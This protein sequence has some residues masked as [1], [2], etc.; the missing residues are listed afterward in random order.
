MTQRTVRRVPDDERAAIVQLCRDGVS[1]PEICLRYGRSE[2]TVRRILREV[3]R[4]P[5][6][7][8][9]AI[10]Q[11]TKDEII[12]R[13]NEGETHLGKLAN[14]LGL[15]RGSVVH[16]LTHAG[17]DTKRHVQSISKMENE[18]IIEE[19]EFLCGTDTLESLC[20]RLDVKPKYLLF[21]LLPREGRTDL[22]E[23]LMETRLR[24]YSSDTDTT[25]EV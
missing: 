7:R 6:V 8:R 15:G 3:G 20:E 10:S 9:G 12:R 11:E 5:I 16:C 19:L 14:S 13:F 25:L 22:A 18:Y 23:R 24:D 21:T 17:Y 1:T 2:T 4:P